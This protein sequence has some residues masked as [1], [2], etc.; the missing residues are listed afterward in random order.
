ML[1]NLNKA[2]LPECTVKGADVRGI[3]HCIRI[4]ETMCKPYRTAEITLLNKDNLATQLFQ[5][6]DGNDLGSG[7]EV[8]FT[9]MDSEG[10][11]YSMTSYLTAI[12]DK[13]FNE[14]LRQETLTLVTATQAFYQDRVNM[15][16]AA[17][18]NIPITTAAQQIH[19]EFIKSPLKIIMP[20]IGMIATDKIGG[21]QIPNIKPF[22]AIRGILDR[23]VSGSVKTGSFI[24]FEN[25]KSHVIGPLESI[26]QQMSP[27]VHLEQRETWGSDYRHMFGYDN[28]KNAIIQLKLYKKESNE[29]GGGKAAMAKYQAQ[30]LVDIAAR[31]VL[32]DATATAVSG[33]GGPVGMMARFFVRGG[34]VQNS[35]LMDQA[36]NPQAVDPSIKAKQEQ[37]FQAMVKDSIN[38]L[39]KVGLQSGF[40]FTVGEGVNI[41]IPTPRALNLET[42]RM[43][44]KMLVAD[45]M[46]EAFFDNREVQGTS[47]AR[48]V[49]QPEN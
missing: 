4:Y 10:K 41:T 45:L 7:D 36:R 37:L 30:S 3:T 16:Q 25:A 14:K 8:V 5:A 1:T 48:L 24:Y 26:F 12:P 40:S 31:K 49:A 22:A 35:Q 46:H 23:A 33:I 20:S 28:A 13:Q 27:T 21:Y 44:G 17:Y 43:T 11:T 6:I 39:V 29:G 47:V 42:D 9:V 34:G 38:M 18:K 2:G 19:S 15:V 32:V